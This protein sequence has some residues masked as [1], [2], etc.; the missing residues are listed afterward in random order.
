MSKRLPVVI[1]D[2]VTPINPEIQCLM[3]GVAPRKKDPWYCAHCKLWF[4][5]DRQDHLDQKHP[6][7]K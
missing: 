7:K 1:F 4:R 6:R 2:E 5:S 3:M